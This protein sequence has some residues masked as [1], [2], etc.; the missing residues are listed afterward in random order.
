MSVQADLPPFLLAHAINSMDVGAR[1]GM[2]RHWRMHAALIRNIDL[3]EPDEAACAVQAQRN[4]P[5]QSWFPVALGGKTGTAPLHVTS[6]PSGSSLYEPNPEVMQRFSAP[7]YGAVA[8]V[9][10]VPL[11]TIADFMDKYQRPVPDL[12]KL[13]V[14]GAEL[15]ILQ[16]MRPEH[17]S[18]LLA[19][20]AEVSF[21][22]FYKKQPL[23]ADV[24]AFMRSKGFVLFDLL[25][26]RAYRFDGEHSHG[27]LRRHLNIIKNRNDISRR[28]IEG[29]ALY[30]RAPEA[31]LA[32]GK[33]ADVL[34]L[35]IILLLY[36]FL[37]EALWLAEAARK[38]GLVS[39]AEEVALVD[40]VKAAA[41]KPG[42]L[43]RA[44]RVGKW[45]RRIAKAL[46]LLRRKPDF[47]LD[48]S[49]DF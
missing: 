13:D 22:E 5:G 16:Q 15:D 36:R 2:Q 43:Q 23:F 44:D 31:V 27:Q 38:A 34:K 42:L 7:S 10:D 30:L 3:F 8:K 9:I 11:M 25:P 28:L 26:S 12:L 40:L 21:V 41:P 32:G 18:S 20:Q 1:G 49:W 29:D 4:E 48:R 47:W 19:V 6:K 35:F 24:D 17:W 39:A 33:A 45:A 37:D 14:Q 46:G